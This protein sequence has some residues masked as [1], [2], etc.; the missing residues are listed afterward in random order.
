MFLI[1]CSN[2]DRGIRW[3]KHNCEKFLFFVVQALYGSYIHVK[4]TETVSFSYILLL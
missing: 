1:R 4:Y 3:K 2:R